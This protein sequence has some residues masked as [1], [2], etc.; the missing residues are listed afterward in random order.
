MTPIRS[1]GTCYQC[2]ITLG[3]DALKKRP[4]QACKHL[5]GVNPEGRC[6]IYATRPD[7]CVKYYCFWLVG[8]GDDDF[9][10]DKSG[11]LVSAY[12]PEGPYTKFNAT[13]HVTNTEKAGSLEDPTSNLRKAIEILLETGCHELKVVFGSKPGSPVIHFRKGRVWRGRTIKNEGPESYEDL[14]LVTF[15]PPIG[16]YEMVLQ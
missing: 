4:G 9:R 7:A 1:C 5:S 11:I 14:T 13:V 15:E 6:S 2:C 8:M 12:E 16:H 3:I 10:P